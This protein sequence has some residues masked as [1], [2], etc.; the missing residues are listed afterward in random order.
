MKR[1]ITLFMIATMLLSLSGCQ[2]YKP[3]KSTA[4]E[5][6]EIASMKYG[7]KTYEANYELF[8]MLLLSAKETVS[9]NDLSKFEGSEGDALLEEA[10]ALALD[11]MYEIYSVFALCDALGINLY[12]RKVNKVVEES[13]TVSIEGGFGADGQEIT[14]LGSYEEYL[15][16]LKAYY[17]M[18]YAVQDLMLRYSYGVSAIGAYYRGTYDDYG[19]KSKEGAIAYTDSQITDYYNSEDTH[20]IFLVF[21]ALSEGKATALRDEI[22]SLG[23]EEAVSTFMLKKTTASESDAKIGLLIGKYSLDSSAY[24]AV[25]EAAFALEE[26]E[27]SLLIEGLDA[28][29]NKGYYI[30]YRAKKSAENL[31]AARTSVAKYYV[32][33]EI[34]KK[35]DEAKQALKASV[36]FTDFY[37]GLAL[38]S[39][40][41]DEE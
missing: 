32:E 14:G 23:S 13:I 35:F 33:N 11:K 8:R 24:A 1:I 40:R 22:A 7:K 20:R 9:G 27:T 38:A 34:G 29:G 39:I 3:V 18:N 36:S 37:K 30:L 26:G 2:K 6:T 12:S 10:R 4:L 16:N 5:S 15:A 41:M 28:Y 31:A 21:T 17:Y 19:N 25:T